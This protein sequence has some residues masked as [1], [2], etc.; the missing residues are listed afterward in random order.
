MNAPFVPGLD[1][2]KAVYAEVAP[3]LRHRFPDL[4]YA[5]ARLARGSD[6]LGFDDARSTDH[7]WGPLLELFVSEEDRHQYAEQIHVALANEL[8]FEVLGYPTHFRPFEGSEAHHGR[9]GFMT[10]RNERPIDHGV[11]VT[12]VRR[13]FWSWLRV[14]PLAE[15]EPED[16]L[17]ISEQN[18]RMVTSGRVFRDDL[19]ELTR[20]RAALGY[21]PRDVWLYLL[22]AQWARIGQEEA[23]PGRTA[24]AG[25][26]LGSRLVAARLVRDVM[27]LAFLMERTYVP[28][29]KWFGS[30]FKQL[31]CA[32]ELAPHLEGTLAASEWPAREAHLVRAY[33]YVA[34][35]HNALGVTDPVSEEVAPFHGRP[36][37]VIH[38]DRFVEAIERAIT[39]EVVRAW[40]PRIG[41]VNQW[42]DATDILDRPS[43]LP[44]LQAVYD[45]PD[46]HK[47]QQ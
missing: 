4:K 9:L 19:G 10:P 29:I 42:A 13:F 36:Y 28:Y 24:E 32:A 45:A 5:A 2:S 17:V 16:W 25:D 20:A 34:R 14:D 18:L 22:A 11:S 15:L 44:R 46:S 39:S 1:L 21:Y 37:L 8:P 47:V 38:A 35:M 31:R 33:E 43:L 30:A 41:S 3:I 7:Y 6:V 12:T 26:D 27:R 23:F 40:P